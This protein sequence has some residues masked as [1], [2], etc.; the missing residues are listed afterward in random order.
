MLKLIAKSILILLFSAIL[1]SASGAPSF[2]MVI[3]HG[4]IIDGTGNPAYYGDVAILNGRIA[5]VGR[6]EEK[7]IT[8]IDASGK[9]VTP[10][11][12]DVHTHADEL[13]DFPKAENFLRMGVTTIIAGNCGDSLT[14]I[15]SVF[16]GIEKTGCSINFA[17][18]VG[19]GKIRAKAMGGSFNRP[20][21]ESELQTMK[22]L[23]K[24]AMEDGAV[25]MS[26][27][28]IYLPGTFSST[29]EIIELAKIVGDYD[30]IYTSHMRDEGNK[31]F[32][33]LEETFAIA[34]GA[35]IRTEI[36]H[37]KLS[38]NTAWGRANEV[39]AAIEA[40]RKEGLDITQDQ[41]AYTAS[42]TALGQLIPDTAREGGHERFL[43][44][45]SDK[46]TKDSI[47]EQMLKSLQSHGRTNF[48]YAVIAYYTNNTAMNG[49]NVP[50]AAKLLRGSDSMDDQLETI[51][52][53]EMHHGASAV[54]HG[55]SE[56]DLQIFMRHPNTMF[57]SD[58][59]IREFGKGVPHPR[60]YGNNARVLSHYVRELHILRLE[61]AIRRMTTL[62]AETFRFKDRGEIKPGYFADLLVFDPEKVRDNSTYEDPHHYSTGFDLV[63]VNG[64]PVI[65][66]GEHTGEKSG[67]VLRHLTPSQANSNKP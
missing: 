67:V 38:G 49:L 9:V 40:A 17:T 21:S 54:F 4:R 35:H 32:D 34:R 2:D 26:T 64:K 31:I 28:L 39:L 18:L 44:R 53:I 58:S 51:L 48:S 63:L 60:G 6:I 23:T 24:K 25:G 33:S 57:A 47:K 46:K 65:L 22:S 52:N 42:S 30:G 43:A 3:R 59:G 16:A 11:F 13:A 41:Y 20:P 29:G 66:N 27:G 55:M 12:I 14:D 36:S 61:D 50:Q 8:E 5:S 19:Q 45:L 56:D 37:I 62:P 10:G 7:G 1:L 15:G